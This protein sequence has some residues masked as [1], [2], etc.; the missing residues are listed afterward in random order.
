[1]EKY[2]VTAENLYNWDEKGFVIGMASATKR[3]MSKD[4][5]DSGRIPNASQDGNREF[6]SLLACIGADGTALPPA[7]VYRGEAGSLL[8]SWVEDWKMENEAFF[9]VSDNGWSSDSLGLHWLRHVFHRSTV[10]KAGNRRRLLIVDGHSSH[11]NMRFINLADEL[12][13]LLL[14]LPPHSTHRLQPLDVSLFAP[15]ATYYSQ[16]LQRLM[17]DSLGMVCMTKGL[18]W[19]IFW[20]AWKQA[21]T[22]TNIA[23]GFAKTGIWPA[24]RAM[25]MSKI[26]RPEPIDSPKAS[27]SLQTPMDCMAVRRIHRQFQKAPSSPLLTKIFRANEKMAARHSV[28]QHVIRGLVSSLQEVKR[29]K[30]RGKR[31]NLI[32]EE[33]SGPQFFSPGRVQAAKDNQT[34][35]EEEEQERR[36]LIDERR[37]QASAKRL[38]MAIEKKER[39]EETAKRRLAEQREPQP[40]TA[41][42]VESAR[43]ACW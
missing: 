13:I 42:P 37:A 2:N 33:D 15:L 30:K 19:K 38:Q 1:M 27:Q 24:N 20:P 35:K 7:L 17:S 3:I 32:G 23:S 12:R 43:Y 40:A 36:R 5:L 31:L 21:F 26:K 29:R 18:F 16:G 34:K 6:L 41:G 25:V 14:I 39:A 8:D 11:V 10:G 22:P 4:A 28:D 9:A